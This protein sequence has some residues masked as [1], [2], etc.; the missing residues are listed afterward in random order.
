MPDMPE[1]LLPFFQAMTP[2]QQHA[3]MLVVL[4]NAGADP[5]LKS[6][7]WRRWWQMLEERTTLAA[8]T[9]VSLIE[10]SSS[11]CSRLGGA[12]GRNAKERHQWQTLLA[13]GEDEAVLDALAAETPTLVAFVR[14]WQDVRREDFAAR[15]AE[16][17]AR[18]EADY[19]V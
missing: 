18:E 19:D 9:S 8:L 7:Y 15:Q 6:R 3:A 12:L 13:G 2:Y 16:E 14:A 5:G 4:L 1:S 17:A 10:W 11:A